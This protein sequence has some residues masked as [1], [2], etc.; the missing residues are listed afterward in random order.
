MMKISGMPCAVLLAAA[1]SAALSGAQTESPLLKSSLGDIPVHIIE[2]RGVHPHEVRFYVQGRDKSVFFARDGIT[3]ALRGEDRKKDWAVKLEF[4]DANEDVVLRGGERRN[5]VFSYFSGP[6]EEWKTGLPSFAEVVYEELWPGIDLVYRGGRNALKYEFRV[7][8]G[9]D[10]KQIRLRYRGAT[11]V[12]TTDAGGLRV[13]TP[14][15]SFADDS[16]VAW[17]VGEGG[18]RAPVD[19]AFSVDESTVRFEVGDYDMSQTLVIDP[20]VFVYCGFI[21]GGGQD[22]A[23]SV[24]V[25]AQGFAYV[26]GGAEPSPTFPVRVGPSTTLPAVT[27]AA[28]VCKVA[29]SGNGLVYCGWIAG[30]FWGGDALN[31]IAIDAGGSAYVCGLTLNNESTFPVTVGPDLTHNTSNRASPKPDAWVAKVNAAGTGLD[32]CGY[33]GGYEHDWALGIAV[34]QT[35]AAYVVGETRS[36]DATQAPT[37]A[38]PFP[39]RGGPDLTYNGGDDVFV[40]KVNPAGTHLD[41]CGYIGGPL[42]DTPRI[43]LSSIGSITIDATGAAYVAGQTWNNEATF[44]VTVGPRLTFWQGA[45]VDGFVAKVNSAGTGLD[46]CGYFGGGYF[47]GGG[48]LEGIHGVAVD[49]QGHAYLSGTTQSPASRLPLTVGPSLQRTNSPRQPIIAKLTPDGS[50]IV[51]CGLIDDA[52]TGASGTKVAIDTHGNAIMIGTATAAFPV[53]DGPQLTV[54]GTYTGLIAMVDRSGKFVRYTGLIGGLYVDEP[55]AVAATPTGTAFVA[56]HAVSG[57]MSGFPV[58]VGPDLTHNQ[59]GRDAYIAKIAFTDIQAL[60]ALRPGATMPLLLTATDDAGLVY[61]V[62]TSLGTGPILLGARVLSL[63][64]DPLLGLSTSGALPGIFR[65][66]TG[67]IDSLGQANASIALP[68]WS[69]LV[70]ITFHTAFVTLSPTAPAGIK[71]ISNTVSA[72]V[73]P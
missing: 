40:A 73:T 1:L 13:Q 10:P 62:G 47:G 48:A 18:V 58:K 29:M 20:A 6:R 54:P 8:P 56:G 5:A 30:G 9:A 68:N 46:Y 66:Y 35:G 43:N 64:P 23:V 36:A 57:E 7:R 61:Q 39:V 63:S 27:G 44:P 55:Y 42:S 12:E 14:V 60:G 19:A 31:G 34:D 70:G 25:D 41:Y 4:V 45:I 26:G 38:T 33:I 3:F 53:K 69:F 49:A 52:G 72:T 24:A 32:Y 17:T 22:L 2:N 28:F 65:A 51:Y 37:N 67:T 71:S 15:A 16:P 50:G 21:G 59:G 11:A